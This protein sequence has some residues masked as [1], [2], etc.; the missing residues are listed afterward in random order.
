MKSSQKKRMAEFETWECTGLNFDDDMIVPLVVVSPEVKSW[1]AE[2]GEDGEM[3]LNKLLQEVN[4]HVFGGFQGEGLNCVAKGKFIEMKDLPTTLFVIYD[5][6]KE[7]LPVWC[8]NVP[9]MVIRFLQN[10][11]L[12]S[13]QSIYAF[14]GVQMDRVEKLPQKRLIAS[15]AKRWTSLQWYLYL[16][17]FEDVRPADAMKDLKIKEGSMRNGASLCRN[18]EQNNLAGF[19][20]DI[21]YVLRKVFSEEYER[22]RAP[23]GGNSA[24][25]RVPVETK[26]G[27]AEPYNKAP[28]NMDWETVKDDFKKIQHTS[29]SRPRVC[30]FPQVAEFIELLYN[31]KPEVDASEEVKKTKVIARALEENIIHHERI[32][33][34][35]RREEVLT[36]FLNK[37]LF[38]AFQDLGVCSIHQAKFFSEGNN[39]E[40]YSV[41][42]AGYFGIF[43]VFM[44]ECKLS[45]NQTP[46]NSDKWH[47][48]VA[49]EF[50]LLNDEYK[51]IMACEPGQQQQHL[52]QLPFIHWA[53]PCISF[54]ETNMYVHLLVPTSEATHRGGFH[55]K[56]YIV[57][58]AECKIRNAH[59]PYNEH[60][61]SN[62][63]SIFRACRAFIKKRIS[64]FKK[65]VE[66][67]NISNEMF[68]IPTTNLPFFP[69]EDEVWTE[70]STSSNTVKVWKV[71]G[72]KK[73]VLKSYDFHMNV[74]LDPIVCNDPAKTARRVPS[75]RLLRI[76]RECAEEGNELA[77][78]A[79]K[80]EMDRFLQAA[81]NFYK[82]WTI[83]KFSESV[84][85]L[86]YDF[87]E[88]HPPNEDTSEDALDEM[89]RRLGKLV[90]YLHKRGVIHGDILPQNILFL[91]D[92]N[93]ESNEVNPVLIDFDTCFME[94]CEKER[95]EFAA[96]N[97]CWKG[98][99]WGLNVTDFKSI[100]SKDVVEECKGTAF[101]FCNMKKEHDT[102]AIDNIFR[103]Y[104]EKRP[105]PSK[106][107]GSPRNKEGNRREVIYEVPHEEAQATTTA[108]TTTNDE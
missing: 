57:P 12:E 78:E 50:S 56:T 28:S 51:R 66:E 70:E 43:P 103:L 80:V 21:Q 7:Q 89:K 52:Q 93:E 98:Y 105:L 8:K 3:N 73:F 75:E 83:H 1:C 2:K 30:V 58:V 102:D 29:S 45:S 46:I 99:Y 47:A 76:L 16:V 69:K 72:K 34:G 35:E 32:L 9:V 84:Q 55:T 64:V 42:F 61:Q 4:V 48:Q 95:P 59:D 77:E 15:K 81:A 36:S 22:G 33:G 38:E 79:G 107:T 23:R 87:R 108:T 31:S 26:K 41:D 37:A 40:V 39:G 67:N 106:P 6:E 92:N 53:V 82:T 17:L 10:L 20:E 94:G 96:N 101:A 68:R 25:E 85:F 65:C 104:A 97:S 88:N 19:E 100:R 14:R 24:D 5:S 90:G 54:S 13:Y 49:A 74:D 63:A 27:V 62:I 86:Q 44:S 71:N 18:V 91:K 11:M 60:Q